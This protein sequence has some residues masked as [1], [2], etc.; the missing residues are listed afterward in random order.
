M[1]FREIAGG[2][3][4][5][6]RDNSIPGPIVL[7]VQKIRNISAPKSNEE[8]KTAPRFLQLELTD[9]QTTIHALE[10]EDIST[11]DMNIPPGTKIYFRS[12]RLNLMQGFLILRSSELQVLG[13]RV[14][15][16]VEKWELARTM[17][18]Y[19]ESGRRMSGANCPP[20]WI[21][22]G[23]KLENSLA[24]ERN[25]KSLQGAGSDGK[26]I[27]ENE[28]FNT[29]RNEAIAEAS[30]TGPKKVYV[31]YLPYCLKKIGTPK[32]K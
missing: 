21:P 26:E 13:G 27:K 23:R 17:L 24:N 28:E 30:K 15:A 12:E 4:P 10:L 11:L 32:V 8:S 2:A 9:G 20:P 5:S 25:F 22:F 16:M 7:Q 18:K 31:Y 3:L 19:A 1:D 6:K 14:E 29:M